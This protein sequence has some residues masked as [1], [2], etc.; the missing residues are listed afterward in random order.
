MFVLI[1][2]M[3]FLLLMFSVRESL[4]LIVFNIVSFDNHAKFT[5]ENK[6]S[7]EKKKKEKKLFYQN[8]TDNFYQNFKDDLRNDRRYVG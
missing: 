5:K 2:N 7:Y 8:I 4:L 1:V 3:R 6:I